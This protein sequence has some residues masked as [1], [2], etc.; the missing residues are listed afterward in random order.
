MEWSGYQKRRKSR[1]KEK[2]INRILKGKSRKNI[3]QIL[4][5]PLYCYSAFILL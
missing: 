5:G 3:K 1:N 4:S 2:K